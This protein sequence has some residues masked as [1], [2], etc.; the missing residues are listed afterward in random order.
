MVSDYVTQMQMQKFLREKLLT[1]V[2]KLLSAD[3]LLLIQYWI[4]KIYIYMV[5]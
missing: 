4:K 5:L 3:S 2:M 1:K